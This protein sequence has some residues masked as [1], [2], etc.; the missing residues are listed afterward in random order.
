[1]Q[2]EAGQSINYALSF[3]PEL[4][5]SLTTELIH[6]LS[7]TLTQ[8]VETLQPEIRATQLYPER[9]PATEFGH[10]VFFYRLESERTKLYLGVGQKVVVANNW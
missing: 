4:F 9:S 7:L 10:A 8:L 2:A 5:L 3:P 1:M 6:D